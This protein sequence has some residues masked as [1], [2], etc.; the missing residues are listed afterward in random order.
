M[1]GSDD[2]AKDD[3]RLEF[4]DGVPV[5]ELAAG[6]PL[7]GTV[8]G[9]PAYLI[10][11]D[12]EYRA[13]G[14]ACTHYGAP[15]E[16]GLVHAGTIRCPWH[17]AR[18]EAADGSVCG[19]P[20]FNPLPRYDVT[21]RD[22]RVYA[23][24]GARDRD[25]LESLRDPPSPVGSVVI[26]GAG[27]AGLTAAETL[28][29]EGHRGEITLVDPDP[30]APYDRPNLSKA[31]L[32]GD[33]PEEWLPLRSDEFLREHDIQRRHGRVESISLSDRRV[34]LEGGETLGYDRLLLAPG[35]TPRSLDVPGADRSNVY[36]LRSLVD[37]RRIIEAAENAERAVVVGA[38]FIGMEVGSAL[39][40]RGLQVT[41]VAPSSV[42]FGRVLGEELGTSFQRLHEEHGVEFRLGRTVTGIGENGVRLDDESVIEA[43]LVVLG[44]GVDPNTD[45]AEAAGLEVDD[46]IVVDAELRASDPSV[47]AAGDVARFP[48]PRTGV[49]IRIEHWVVACRQ[50]RTAARNLL[51]HGDPFVDPPFFWTR[52]FD[53]SVAYVGHATRWDETRREGD[54]GEASCAVRYLLGGQ[55]AAQ[56]A[57]GRPEKSLAAEVEWEAAVRRD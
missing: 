15:L 17:H 9:E 23:R 34:T 35:S 55:T 38:S 47:Y 3:Q 46:G 1:S 48:D 53:R 57:L 30:D 6:S 27:A 31:F 39:R 54:C 26:V 25:A 45:L 43:S 24:G 33:A 11:V 10:A 37:C 14:A 52:Q 13:F 2:A 44:V 21:L 36:R 42:P 7:F 22:A 29:R 8:E 19:G 56:A 32:S 12:G 40:A 20:A 4:T 49:P 18:F 41:I 5:S 28:R 51:G 16:D 50:G